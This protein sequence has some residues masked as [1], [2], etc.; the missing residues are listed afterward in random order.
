M[1]AEHNRQIANLI[2]QGNIAEVNP[3]DSRVRVAVGA[4]LSG[5]LPYFVP[6]A[7]GVSV[8]RPPSIGEN[9]LL[10]SPSGETA[11]GIVLCGLASDQ[12]P[13][14]DNT[15]DDTVIRFSDGAR[16]E[17]N[18]ISGSLKITGIKTAVIQAA[19]SLTIDTPQAEF[20][21][22]LTVKGL[23]TYLSG[24]AGSNS[25]GGSA[26]S[27]AGN[28]ELAGS[29]T[30]QGGKISSNGVVLDSHTH[31]GDSGGRTGQPS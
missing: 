30:Q 31:P 29:L 18:H 19:Q 10:F 23:L 21:G 13:S 7:G 5:W 9:C 24:I 25:A 16:F 26:A 15:A 11:N 8:H 2:R 14:P 4:L 20:T 27:I 22:M 6:A 12:F 28:I 1:Q 17:Y 3:S